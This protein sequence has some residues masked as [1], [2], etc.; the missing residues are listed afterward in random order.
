MVMIEEWKSVVGYEGLY[1]VSSLGNVR[2]LDRMSNGGRWGNYMKQGKP[3]IPQSRP[4]GYKMV[5]LMAG[6]GSQ[7]CASI[8]RIV[9]EAFIGP[10]SNGMVVDHLNGERSDNR[11]EN[12]EYVSMR[13]NICR[14][15]RGLKRK[16]KSCTSRGVTK[17]KWNRYIASIRINGK[18][19]YLGSFGDEESASK[20]YEQAFIVA[21]REYK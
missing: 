15:E 14:G 9:A 5:T 4:N 3:L 12:L 17:S 2:S 6:Q 19:V 13:E 16:N 10:P 20:A 21:E 11:L 8:H 18:A 7:K 1:E